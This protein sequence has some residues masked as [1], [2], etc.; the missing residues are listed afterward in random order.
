MSIASVYGLYTLAVALHAPQ[1]EREKC[2]MALYSRLLLL[3][4]AISPANYSVEQSYNALFAVRS[5]SLVERAPFSL[6]TVLTLVFYIKR[7]SAAN[8]TLFIYG[9]LFFCV[10]NKFQSAQFKCFEG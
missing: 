1:H 3:G 5:L 7:S 9:A 6:M 2:H 4:V 8:E 10:S